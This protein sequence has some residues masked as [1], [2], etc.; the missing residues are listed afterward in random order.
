MK[1]NHYTCR[2]CKK[3]LKMDE[4]LFSG[5]IH[6]SY[7]ELQE[8]LDKTGLYH[9]VLCEACGEELIKFFIPEEEK[10]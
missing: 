2:R 5:L 6:G 8:K 1:F 9:F 7:D 3:E 4:R 10:I